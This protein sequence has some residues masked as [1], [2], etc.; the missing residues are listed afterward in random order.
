MSEQ[1]SARDTCPSH[2]V[3]KLDKTSYVCARLPAAKGG[4]PWKSARRGSPA[5]VSRTFST[6]SAAGSSRFGGA[7]HWPAGIIPDR[8][9]EESGLKDL[10]SSAERIRDAARI[11]E[12]VHIHTRSR[13]GDSVIPNLKARIISYLLQPKAARTQEAY[14]L[15][16]LSSERTRRRF[17]ITPQRSRLPHGHGPNASTRVRMSLA[18][19]L[20]LAGTS[21]ATG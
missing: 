2:S 12:F 5:I 15:L 21:R 20:G 17:H 18:L 8:K 7:A 10:L 3:S 14:G 4:M 13:R 9:A 6:S 19:G 11:V 1:G 16:F